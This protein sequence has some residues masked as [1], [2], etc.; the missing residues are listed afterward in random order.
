LEGYRK[1]FTSPLN[2]GGGLLN[3]LNY[4]TVYSTPKLFKTGQI[5]PQAVLKRRICYRYNGIGTGTASCYS[6]TVLPFS[7]LFISVKSLK[8]HS[9]S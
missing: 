2:Y 1:K 4:E 9:N 5:T 8:N 6:A 3:L 7:F